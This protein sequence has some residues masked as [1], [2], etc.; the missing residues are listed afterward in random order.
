MKKKH[1]LVVLS[2]FLIIFF[3]FGVLVYIVK[4]H[5][6]YN[7]NNL[8]NL[9]R[10]KEKWSSYID[11]YG[12]KIAYKMVKKEYLSKVD[13]SH[14]ELHMFGEL[15][16]K[17]NGLDGIS[18]CD[19]SFAYACFH[20]FFIAAVAD[21]GIPVITE[22]D[23][24]CKR[25]A[26]GDVDCQHG[27][28]HGILEYVGYKN[29]VKALPLCDAVESIP[30]RSGCQ[31]GVFMGYFFPV[32]TS[33]DGVKIL[34]VRKFDGKNAYSPCTEIERRFTSIC[35]ISS[36]IYWRSLFGKDYVKIGRLCEGILDVNNKKSCYVGVG[37]F[38]PRDYPNDLKEI[39]NE[40][41]K[42]PTYQGDLWCS[43]GA[44]WEIK[45]NPIYRS[46][47][48]ELCNGFNE[49]ERKECNNS[50]QLAKELL[51]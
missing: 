50:D 27:I 40:C 51:S 11:K 20:G 30:A 39:K 43:A 45:V 15:L 35:Y 1:F 23:K 36:V 28:G 6:K 9:S 2:L 33:F 16:Y 5:E 47:A 3:E 13:S 25:V 41:D 26:S 22:L 24:A 44:V 10:N 38:L 32:E 37:N 29:L 42:M 31:S 17:K 8:V 48:N 19:S 34:Y 4:H 14:T 49:I 18:I 46:K 12:A 7:N 21:R